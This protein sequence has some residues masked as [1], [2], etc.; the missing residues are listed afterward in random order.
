L[1]KK[2]GQ[3]DCDSLFPSYARFS[4]IF[5]PVV[6]E[7][8]PQDPCR[9]SPCG[10][11]SQCRAI[12]DHAVCSCQVGFIGTPPS[13]RP[14]CVVSADCPQDKACVNQ[15]CKDPCSGQC[16]TNARCNVVNHNPICSC[17]PGFTGDPFVNCRKESKHFSTMFPFQ[18]G[19][20]ISQKFSNSLFLHL[21]SHFVYLY[22]SC[23]LFLC[24]HFRS[25]SCVQRHLLL[26][27]L[28]IRAFLRP[29]ALTL[30]A[31]SS[32]RMLHALACQITLGA[33][34]TA[35]LS[36]SSTLIAPVIWLA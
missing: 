6:I 3:I 7:T 8:T 18:I 25:I 27:T 5:F 17:T 32:G 31:G 4:P 34:P 14:E 30:S 23:F 20:I 10:P 29:A 15:K 19:K 28:A 13:C 33:L 12:N 22:I 2:C 35:A 21:M 36:A 24:A 9:P 11:N 26:R 16:G 1:F